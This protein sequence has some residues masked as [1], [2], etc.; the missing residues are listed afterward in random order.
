MLCCACVHA[1]VIQNPKPFRVELFWISPAV[2]SEVQVIHRNSN[3]TGFLY[4]YSI[5]HSV[6]VASS[7]HPALSEH[8]C[9]KSMLGSEFNNC[10]ESTVEDSCVFSL[11]FCAN[12]IS[13][14]RSKT[15]TK[16]VIVDRQSPESNLW[17]YCTKENWTKFTFAIDSGLPLT[18]RWVLQQ[19]I[20]KLQRSKPK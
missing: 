3:K 19:V 10:I 12:L 7:C 5:D 17:I 9:S 18:R 16:R 11:L 6:L 14:T 1:C 2:R 13:S 20:E 8:M 4:W 15:H